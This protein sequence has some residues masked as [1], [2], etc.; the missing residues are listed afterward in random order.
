MTKVDDSVKRRDATRTR[1]ALLLAAQELFGRNGYARTTMRD[2]GELAG[3][4]PALIARYF[5][6]KT[7]IYLASLEADEP[8]AGEAVAV[9]QLSLDELIERMIDRITRVGPSP[10][11]QA[12]VTPTAEPEVQ[13]AARRILAERTVGPL[14][15]Q[16][17]A[18][19]L[20]RAELRAEVAAA[21]LAG[22]VL[23]RVAGTFETLGSAP[24]DDVVEITRALLH[25]LLGN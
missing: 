15:D 16:A 8:V 4:D 6:N 14:R 5:G 20:D 12:A 7:A 10:V 17:E 21:A 25:D 2:I 13:E 3:V 23:G 19:G 18:A 22:V 24:H 9:P 1:Q 11:L